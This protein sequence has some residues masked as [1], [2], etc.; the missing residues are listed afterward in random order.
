MGNADVIKEVLAK[1]TKPYVAVGE[2]YHDEEAYDNLLTIC[3]IHDYCYELIRDNAEL[4]GYEYSIDKARK[5]AIKHIRESI[6]E[7]KELLDDLT[8]ESEDSDDKGDNS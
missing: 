2:T 3:C 8:A 5:K 4:R 6:A 1:F 7:M